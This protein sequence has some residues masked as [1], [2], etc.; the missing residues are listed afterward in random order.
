MRGPPKRPRSLPKSGWTFGMFDSTAWKKGFPMA[1]YIVYDAGFIAGRERMGHW[2]RGTR[3]VD[4]P[5]FGYYPSVLLTPQQPTTV[6]KKADWTTFNPEGDACPNCGAVDSMVERTITI[7]DECSE[8]PLDI[9]GADWNPKQPRIP[10]PTCNKPEPCPCPRP[11][12]MKPQDKPGKS[13]KQPPRVHKGPNVLPPIPTP[14]HDPNYWVNRQ[15]GETHRGNKPT[16]AQWRAVEKVPVVINGKQRYIDNIMDEIVKIWP[17]S[18]VVY[19]R[20][21]PY[22]WVVDN[23]INLQGLNIKGIKIDGHELTYE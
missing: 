13:G 12:K 15:T 23:K 19:R 11:G 4:L 7:C 6:Q 20:N 1:G 8:S 18:S 22:V 21:P 16:G 14:E 3:L 10:C 9:L 2:N 17:P 5:N